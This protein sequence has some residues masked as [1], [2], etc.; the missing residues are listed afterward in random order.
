VAIYFTIRAFTIREPPK[1]S[2]L[3][4]KETRAVKALVRIAS[5]FGPSDHSKEVA[6]AA[7][8]HAW[9]R[10]L[11]G[12]HR[13]TPHHHPVLDRSV[14]LSPCHSSPMMLRLS[15]GQNQL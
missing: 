11:L 7:S 6:P 14:Y 10:F 4:L 2:G 3:D 1:E 5:K 12:F 8:I 15:K 9:F 13:L